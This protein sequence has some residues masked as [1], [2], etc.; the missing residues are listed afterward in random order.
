MLGNTDRG[1]TEL[2]APF[3][4]SYGRTRRGTHHTA[5]KYYP[6]QQVEEFFNDLTVDISQLIV[7]PFHVPLGFMD[8]T[9]RSG[10]NW[11]RELLYALGTCQVLVALLSPK[12]LSSEWCGKEWHA[13]EQRDIHGL[14][15]NTSPRQGCIIPVI[16]APYPENALPPQV[17]ADMIF[18]P[19]RAPDPKVPDLYQRMGIF[20]LKRTGLADEYQMTV[21]E[22]ALDI[23]SV[24]Y[25]QYLRFREFE[26]GDLRDVLGG[27]SG[28]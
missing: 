10:M 15:Q 25:D 9:M 4:L 17:G 7:P 24:Y 8:R 20:G 6:D 1:G 3:F 22:L 23:A 26:P 16:W 11:T 28:G 14:G 21:Y 18:S 12:Y 19:D 5:A 2:G 13:F 27:G